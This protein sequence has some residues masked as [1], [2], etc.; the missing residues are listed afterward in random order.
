MTSAS[1]ES[2]TVGD[3][4]ARNDDEARRKGVWQPSEDAALLACVRRHG[5]Q[6]WSAIAREVLP[7]R[8]GKQCRERWV[9]QLRPGLK[10]LPWT[11][12]EDKFIL[13]FVKEHGFKWSRLAKE[14]PG[15][16]DNAVKN[17]WNSSLRKVVLGLSLTQARRRELAQGA[18]QTQSSPG[19]ENERSPG[20][21]P[22]DKSRRCARQSNHPT[23][24]QTQ[25]TGRRISTSEADGASGTLRKEE[26]CEAVLG[27]LR[28]DSRVS[29]RAELEDILG[30]EVSSRVLRSDLPSLF[31]IVPSRDKRC[32]TMTDAS[33]EE[34]GIQLDEVVPALVEPYCGTFDV[35]D[36]A[37]GH[38]Y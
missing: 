22:R 10:V 31:E 9:N 15:R 6:S 30:T 11:E 38:P 32:S 33:H 1:D 26:I 34:H 18:R 36:A 14:L 21:V 3:G 13:A 35:L 23:L 5:A 27:V 29:R 25:E 7:H 4:S 28:A 20:D 2:T 16:S 12:A 19:T 37:F 24:A 8:S 17:H